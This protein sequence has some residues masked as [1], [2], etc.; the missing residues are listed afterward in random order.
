MGITSTLQNARLAFEAR[1][2]PTYV[3]CTING[4]N[5]VALDDIGQSI[6]PIH[7]TAFTQVLLAQSS[8]ATIIGGIDN[9]VWDA[10]ISDF[11]VDNSFGKRLVDALKL[12]RTKP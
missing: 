2:G 5:L 11:T 12:K 8:S 1:P 7:T 4:G 3:Q 10:L 9:A 6:S